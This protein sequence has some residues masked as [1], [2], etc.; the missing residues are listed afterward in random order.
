M[1]WI[2]DLEMLI[3][4]RRM[5]LHKLR[6][7]SREELET[8]Q[9]NIGIGISL[10]N[11][12]FSPENIVEATRWALP[13]AREHVVIYV[14]DTIHAINLSVR[15][16]ISDDRALRITTRY[17]Q[18]L[19]DAV[20]KKVDGEFSEEEREKI[21]YATWRDLVDSSY[22]KKVDYLYG[23]YESNEEFRTCIQDIVRGW[24]SKETRVFTDEDIYKFGTYILEELPEVMCRVPIKGIVYEAYAY[25]FDGELPEI[26]EEFQFGELFPEVKEHVMDTEP[27]I[28]LEVH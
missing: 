16:R 15:N 23:L 20:K 11:K 19:L 17:G 4:L 14:A 13:F 26:I 24:I 1:K 2:R 12:W 5:E 27:K 7:G 9:F 18:E 22:Q 8:K 25:P 21:V 3:S 10:G 6:G 28:F